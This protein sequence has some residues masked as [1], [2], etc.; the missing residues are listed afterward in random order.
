M[1]GDIIQNGL[2]SVHTQIITYVYIYTLMHGP[3]ISDSQSWI[4]FVLRELLQ[5]CCF[6]LF[7]GFPRKPEDIGTGEPL[8]C[9]FGFEV[10]GWSRW[11]GS[12]HDS[13]WIWYANDPVPC[14]RCPWYGKQKHIPDTFPQAYLSQWFS[15]ISQVGY[16]SIFTAPVEG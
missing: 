5:C 13:F 12:P 15:Y 6:P 10:G 8:F 7:L 14:C 1:Q 3:R 4:S 16:I 2:P 9:N 11:R